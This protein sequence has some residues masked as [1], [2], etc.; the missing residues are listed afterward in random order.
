MPHPFSY[1]EK[2]W[3][4]Y[5]EK[6]QTFKTKEDLGKPKYYV[7][8]MFPYPSGSGLHVG[9]PE[10]YTAT[11]IV[12]RYKRMCNYNVLH[13]MGWDAFGLP[14]ERYASVTGI[15]PA[16]TTKQ[17]IDNFRRQLK[18]LGFSYDWDKEINTTDP[19]YYKWTQWIFLKIFNSYYDEKKDKACP[20]SELDVPANLN[21]IEKNDFINSKRLAYIKEAPVNFCSE[22]K[23][24]LANEEVEEW[25]SKGYTVE[26]RQM[27]QWLLR[28]TAYSKRLIDDL[29]LVDWPKSTLLLQKNWIGESKGVYINF[30]LINKNIISNSEIN[31]NSNSKTKE[32]TNF[33]IKATLILKLMKTLILK[34][35]A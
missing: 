33:K 28:I 16:T 7:L 4:E 9:H 17:N 27:R 29:N 2:K 21:E 3:Q 10:G 8:D 26:R 24:I 23:T 6:N 11:D 25:K 19:N 12:A 30:E 31:V 15:H 22:L 34:N 14:A 13:P 18:S 35:L 5:W 1:I 32:N 20:I